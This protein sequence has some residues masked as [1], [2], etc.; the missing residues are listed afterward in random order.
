MT[1]SRSS[2]DARRRVAHAVD[3]LVDR[4]FLLDIGVGA[5]DVGL[6]LVIVVV[7]DEILDRV[8]GKERAELAVELR[9]Q[10]LVGRENQ[11]RALRRLDHLGHGEGLARAGDAEQHLGAVVAAHPFHQLDDRL[12]LVASRLEIRLDDEAKP[13][14]GL[15][16]PGRAVRH[17]RALAELG[18]P[19]AQQPVERLLRGDG[20]DAACYLPLQGGGR[21]RSA[22]SGGGDA[23]CPARYRYPLHPACLRRATLSLQRGVVEPAAPPPRSPTPGPGRDRAARAGSCP[24]SPSA[25]PREDPLGV[26]ARALW[27]AAKSARR[28]N[29][30]SGGGFSPVCEPTP[31]VP[32][33]MPGLSSFSS[34]G[35][36]AGS[37]S[38]AALARVGWAGSRGFLGRSGGFAIAGIWAAAARLSPRP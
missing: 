5:R 23:S 16:R 26:E 9:R 2:S 31:A 34:A 37:C 19:L 32:F 30:L 1:S 22:R 33:S 18:P 11:R 3:L 7:G 12:R 17:P 24:H 25:A 14:L 8:V 15:V 21:P 27:A 10:G 29:E 38:R 36:M 4:G 35:A 13:A 20:G 28:S 6:R